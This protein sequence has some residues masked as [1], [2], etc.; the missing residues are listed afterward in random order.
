[1]RESSHFDGDQT[2]GYNLHKNVSKLGGIE[3]FDECHRIVPRR[4][5]PARTGAGMSTLYQ[6]AAAQMLR[7]LTGVQPFRWLG[8]RSISLPT[9]A[10]GIEPK[11]RMLA[12]RE[13]MALHSTKWSAA[14]RMSRPKPSRLQRQRCGNARELP[15]MNPGGQIVPRQLHI[16][17][18]SSFGKRFD[19]GRD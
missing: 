2:T 11:A 16:A 9:C 1:M 10:D 7:A 13:P 6:F 17:R 15:Q 18:S 12:E 4:Y 3:L 19:S 5:L 14:A 8:S